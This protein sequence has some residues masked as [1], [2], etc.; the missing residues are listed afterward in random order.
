MGIRQ[1]RYCDISGAEEGPG[2]DVEAHELHIDQ[3]RLQIDLVAGE[4][5]KLLALLRPYIDAGRVEASTPSHLTG[6]P[7][8]RAGGTTVTRRAGP[9]LSAEERDELV[10]WALDHNIPV[11]TNKKFKHA[12]IEQWQRER[13]P[14]ER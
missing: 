1:I 3:M 14:A 5:Q 7:S 11:P 8:V 9:R 10:Q 6:L 12:V 4:Y 2:Q 13:T